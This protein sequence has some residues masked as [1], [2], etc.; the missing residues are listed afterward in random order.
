MVITA[1]LLHAAEPV[2]MKKRRDELA[3][4]KWGMFVCWS[5]STFS[6]REWTPGVKD[7]E[8]FRAKECDTDQW[9]RTAKE[10]GMDYILFL[11]K[12]HDGYHRTQ[13]FAIEWKDGDVWKELARG[14]TIAGEKEIAFRPVTARHVR[15]NILKATEVPTIE[16]FDLYPPSPAACK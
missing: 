15:L 2:N 13:Q 8:F 7:V 12:H 16:E 4:L 14:A 1:T 3:N 10:A 9:A 6:G 5:F 11:A